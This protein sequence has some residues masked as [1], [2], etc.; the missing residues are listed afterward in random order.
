MMQNRW[1]AGGCVTVHRTSQAEAQPATMAMPS[2]RCGRGLRGQGRSS[3][4]MPSARPAR[5]EPV[6][7]LL[8]PRR[9]W[10][11]RLAG[12]SSRRPWSPPWPSSGST[13]G[14]GML[15]TGVSSSA[16]ASVMNIGYVRVEM[17]GASDWW[18][19]GCDSTIS[20][21]AWRR[22]RAGS[23]VRA[24][25]RNLARSARERVLGCSLSIQ[26]LLPRMLRRGEMPGLG[27]DPAE[28]ELDAV[29]QPAGASMRELA[30]WMQRE[31]EARA[32][33]EVVAGEA[34]L[35]L[36]GGEDDEEVL[37]AVEVHGEVAGVQ[38]EGGVQ[39]LGHLF[40]G[41]DVSRPSDGGHHGPAQDALRLLDLDGAGEDDTHR[42]GRDIGAFLGLHGGQQRGCAERRGARCRRRR[43]PR[44]R[45]ARGV[46]AYAGA[47]AVWAFPGLVARH[48]ATAAADIASAV[49]H[50]VARVQA[51]EAEARRLL[52][53]WAA[54][55]RRCRAKRSG[56]PGTA[57]SV[58]A[59]RELEPL[60]VDLGR[61]SCALY[62][63][64]LRTWPQASRGRH[65]AHTS[66]RGRV[67][68][69]GVAKQ[70]AGAPSVPGSAGSRRPR[71]RSARRTSRRG[72]PASGARGRRSSPRW[73]RRRP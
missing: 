58:P 21:V 53:R 38:G 64:H 42:G 26:Q 59:S 49:A 7:R 11:A 13:A 18:R 73:S 68:R 47:A 17:A 9:Q 50:P 10:R 52:G 27:G 12:S 41:D 39:H 66:R 24:E 63:V 28:L 40:R 71:C 34:V 65:P 60:L 48:E 45:R 32:G 2:A 35:E 54:V 15:G 57:T 5:V 31:G 19:E 56:T 25:S 29:V 23:A 36:M 51:A 33:D 1:S 43:G 67:G 6:R 8:R 16:R 72:R 70:P 14:A 3:I 44:R 22:M 55:A 30:P 20:K 61:G 62:L 37:R 46:G 69:H 4:C